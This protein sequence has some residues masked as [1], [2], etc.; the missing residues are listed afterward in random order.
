MNEIFDKNTTAEID[1]KL[2][3]DTLEHE[4]NFIKIF[5]VIILLSIVSFR[6][7]IGYWLKFGIA[8]PSGINSTKIN[9]EQD[10][11]QINY[12]KEEQTAKT[13]K[14]K[15]LTTG[16]LVTIIPQATYKISG[17]TVGNTHSQSLKQDTLNDI[18]LY[19]LGL[20]WGKLGNK[21]FYNKYFKNYTYSNYRVLWS[22]PKSYSIPVTSEYAREHYS[23][24]YIIP[25]NRNVMAALLK[26]KTWDKV[27][28]EGDL[29]DV[30]QTYYSNQRLDKTSLSRTDDGWEGDRGSGSSEIIF[31]KKIKIGNLIYQ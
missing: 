9:I 6:G 8:F 17:L 23:H 21:Y 22:V 18:A 12:S 19:D 1:A 7:W 2:H 15:T 24:S 13:F 10:P 31:L 26:I 16:K 4:N 27:E 5:L 29:V 11:T 14:Y 20:S 25:A 28:L 30:E 3:W